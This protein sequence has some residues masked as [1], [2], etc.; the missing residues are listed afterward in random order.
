MTKKKETIEIPVQLAKLL[1]VEPE[2]FKEPEKYG[3][4]QTVAKSLLKVLV[5]VNK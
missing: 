2:D 1:I 5:E 3:E 4:V